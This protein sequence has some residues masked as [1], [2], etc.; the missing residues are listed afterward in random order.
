MND[1]DFKAKVL[2]SLFLHPTVLVP[3]GFGF[4][5]LLE[6][7]F[8][9]RGFR[10][11]G[12]VG[13]FVGFG[14]LVS[15]L[16]W[17]FDEIAHKVFTKWHQANQRQQ[18]AILDNL[19]TKLCGDEDTRDET[20]LRKLRALYKVFVESVKSGKVRE[21]NFLSTAERLFNNSIKNLEISHIKWEQAMALPAESRRPLLNERNRLITEVEASIE[22][23]SHAVEE[24]HE[25]T[26]H[27]TD[28]L[29][30][31]RQ[32]MDKRLEFAKR[33]EGKIQEINNFED[34]EYDGRSDKIAE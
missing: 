32:E 17:R 6:S 7:F 3:L 11:L 9:I 18:N 13:L 19:D 24:V 31:I 10:V 22:T 30:R 33:V 5:F 34:I 15:R 29:V 2:Q 16:T 12:G 20:A 26:A 8:G 14:F 28:E 27:K 4:L 1:K 25:L 21:Y 23:L